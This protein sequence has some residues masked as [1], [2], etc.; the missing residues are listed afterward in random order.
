MSSILVKL[1]RDF[2]MGRWLGL[3]ERQRELL[4]AIAGIEGSERG[5]AV[6]QV[7]E[8]SQRLHAGAM[9]ASQVTQLLARLTD[10]G[11][12][13]K[14]GHGAYAFAL[15]LL[16]GFVLRQQPRVA[17]PRD[18]ATPVRRPRTRRARRS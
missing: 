2:F 11:L 17:P 8:A 18:G 13:Y 1:D 16:R 3:T 5:S 6:R 15:P 7:V 14:E 12:V 4:V 9:G 10:A